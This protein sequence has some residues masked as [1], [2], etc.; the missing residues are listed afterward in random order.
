[1]LGACTNAPLNGFKGMHLEGGVRIPYIVAWPGRIPGGRVDDRTVSSLDIVPT[2]AAAAGAKL[3]NGTDGVDLL[4]YLTGRNAGVPNPTLYWR[5]GPNFAIRDG[6][7][8]MWDV[9]RADPKESAS[10]GAEVTPDGTKPAGS[11]FGRYVMLYDLGKDPGERA[12]MAEARPD[13]VAALR[14]RLAEWDKGNVAPQWTSMRQSVRRQDG[15][16]IKL[17]D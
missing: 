6:A 13:L 5:A 12:N 4:P 15:Q 8:K 1:M 9:D 11:P 2:A 10:V 7:L 14:A 17:Y 3:P 16:L